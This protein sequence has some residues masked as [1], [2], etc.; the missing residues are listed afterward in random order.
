MRP[1]AAAT[2][3][4]VIGMKAET[5]PT[6]KPE[7]ESAPGIDTPVPGALLDM[8]GVEIPVNS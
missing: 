5:R 6:H 8:P 3:C 4:T 2:Y 7:P 1:W